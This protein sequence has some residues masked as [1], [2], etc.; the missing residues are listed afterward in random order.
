MKHVTFMNPLIGDDVTYK[1]ETCNGVTK[2]S[3][4]VVRCNGPQSSTSKILNLLS[5]NNQDVFDTQIDQL[6]RS[7]PTSLLSD[8]QSNDFHR[9][10]WSVENDSTGYRTP[11]NNSTN[12]SE[13]SI[14]FS[15]TSLKDQNG[16][17]D[18]HVIWNPIASDNGHLVWNSI[19]NASD[20][21][22]LEWG[23][24]YN[25]RDEH[26]PD[27][28]NHLYA[29]SCQQ[30]P[31][32]RASHSE[33][34][35]LSNCNKQ[36][37]YGTDYGRLS[38]PSDYGSAS[39]SVVGRS[40]FNTLS[41]S[42]NLMN[43][44]AFTCDINVPSPLASDSAFTDNAST[45]LTS[46]SAFS[47]SFVDDCFTCNCELS[48]LKELSFS[49]FQR[50]ETGDELTSTKVMKII[51]ASNNYITTSNSCV[52]HVSLSEADC[53]LAA[54]SHSCVKHVSLTEADCGLAPTSHSCVK[55]VSL[56][57][58][59]CGLAPTSNSCVKHVNLSEA[60]CGLATTS[61]SCVKHVNL[62]E[63]AADKQIIDFTSPLVLEA[64]SYHFDESC[65]NNFDLLD[66]HL[67][68]R[69]E[70]VST[71]WYPYLKGNSRCLSPEDEVDRVLEG[72][73]SD[74]DDDEVV[75]WEDE[76]LS[77]Q[78]SDDEQ[79]SGSYH[80]NDSNTSPGRLGFID[81][82]R[83]IGEQGSVDYRSSDFSS[84]SQ[85]ASCQLTVGSVHTCM[86]SIPEIDTDEDLIHDSKG[87]LN[88]YKSYT[89]CAN[90]EIINQNIGDKGLPNRR[91]KNFEITNQKVNNFEITN[92][93]V[94]NFEITNQKINLNGK[95]SEHD[96]STEFNT[97]TIT[98]NQ[99]IN[100]EEQ[101]ISYESASESNNLD[102]ANH[103][104]DLIQSLEN[105]SIDTTLMDEM[106]KCANEFEQVLTA[107]SQNNAQNRASSQSTLDAL[108]NTH[109]DDAALCDY[110]GLQYAVNP[111]HNDS[112]KLELHFDYQNMNTRHNQVISNTQDGTVTSLHDASPPNAS[113]GY[114]SLEKSTLTDI[115]KG[116]QPLVISE[117]T[118][119]DSDDCYEQRLE[120]ILD[121]LDIN[122]S[123]E[124]QAGSE[125]QGAVVMEECVTYSP[126]DSD[127]D[128]MFTADEDIV[129]KT[130]FAGTHLDNGLSAFSG[131]P[132]SELSKENIGQ[133]R[134]GD[135]IKV[136]SSE[137]STNFH[138]VTVR[139]KAV[140][141]VHESDSYEQHQ[142]HGALVHINVDK[143]L[144]QDKSRDGVLEHYVTDALKNS[145]KHYVVSSAND[146]E[147][148][149]EDGVVKS[150]EIIVQEAVI[151]FSWRKKKSVSDDQASQV[152]RIDLG[153][154]AEN[155]PIREIQVRRQ[156]KVTDLPAESV[157]F[158]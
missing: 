114:W 33:K 136:L 148:P 44:D 95:V 102:A 132:S 134:L 69:E 82:S 45:P 9:S 77:D 76:W 110:S 66:H 97:F 20:N 25:P 133:S 111:L 129:T 17:D 100:Y 61:N 87:Q 99:D 96:S 43:D 64:T 23:S 24:I 26:N 49:N 65:V 31:H 157:H 92:Q 98:T 56:S 11:N 70:V 101:N 28:F 53:G 55:H 71:P 105:N 145:E 22:Q 10:H 15:T 147:K 52:K 85:P 75:Q 72:E 78:F 30:L 6:E 21:D 89:E 16:N 46:D 149:H 121:M 155:K 47:Q 29:T 120:T 124:K 140:R 128:D 138:E 83:D 151:V 4:H 153:G 94:N 90:F 80:L 146:V 18:D 116:Y 38:S 91:A 84:Y 59:D 139:R 103:N 68:F 156:F 81:Y 67:D 142:S 74:K 13:L 2:I 60:D 130:A 7:V 154:Q 35:M 42:D 112:H 58:D 14:G 122:D 37:L 73:E 54:T 62:S 135:S 51:T 50:S 34:E 152:Q 41:N 27:Y 107:M 8:L 57:E 88:G 93:N 118:I 125:R 119:I 106:M 126:C 48:D 113:K 137:N 141:L 12:G 39:P 144:E 3:K 150:D 79:D 32:L 131:L 115:N 108:T 117:L 123:S 1:S 104:V 40:P 127:F 36:T 19:Q 158:V 63:A 143:Q 109:N 5:S 86:P